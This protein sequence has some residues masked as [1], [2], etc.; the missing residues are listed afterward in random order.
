MFVENVRIQ[1]V[2]NDQLLEI[3]S[4]QTFFLSVDDDSTSIFQQ[5]GN[6]PLCATNW[7]VE[8]RLG[9]VSNMLYVCVG[10]TVKEREKETSCASNSPT[11]KTTEIRMW[12]PNNHKCTCVCLCLCVCVC[13]SLVTKWQKLPPFKNIPDYYAISKD[14][15]TWSFSYPGKMSENYFWVLLSMSWGEKSSF[16]FGHLHEE[17]E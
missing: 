16:A 6:V 4:N 7:G 12:P 2:N 9:F 3:S 11:N 17:I 8:M 15:F 5:S 13:V 14:K 10:V 1:I